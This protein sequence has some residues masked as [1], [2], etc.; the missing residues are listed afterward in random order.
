MLGGEARGRVAGFWVALAMS[1]PSEPDHL[2]A[3]L[4]LYAALSEVHSPEARHA[5]KALLWEHLLSW[6]PPYLECV[7]RVGAA[8]Y[9]DWARLVRA[10][11]LAEARR[12]GPPGILP[13]HMREAPGIA[14]PRQEGGDA[15]LDS[16]LAPI[17][18]GMI[19]AKSD[20]GRCADD[21]SLGLR[22][23]ERKYVLRSLFGQA[24]EAVLEWL[25]VEA[26]AWSARHCRRPTAVRA[27]SEFWAQRADAAAVLFAELEEARVAV[28]TSAHTADQ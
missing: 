15:F 5:R 24:P 19:I 3:L 8:F 23:G 7:E 1:P 28:A 25:A 13:L 26:A 27:V 11:L 22:V 14:D 20:L 12:L 18:T 21:L 9:A 6:L 4:G 10:A 17:R 16:L 2:A